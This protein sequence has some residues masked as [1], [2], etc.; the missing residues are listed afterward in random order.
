MRYPMEKSIHDEVL[1]YIPE[2]DA[3][4]AKDGHDAYLDDCMGCK[5]S[6]SSPFMSPGAKC[7]LK[8]IN[9]GWKYVCDKFLACK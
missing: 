2:K 5:Y 6:R 7:V 9:C 1:T 4:F 8:G 3:Y